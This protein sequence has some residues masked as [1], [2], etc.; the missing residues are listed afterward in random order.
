METDQSQPDETEIRPRVAAL[1][2]KVPDDIPP[3]FRGRL[4]SDV[5]VID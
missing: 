4:R 3:T 1:P 2:K 5:V